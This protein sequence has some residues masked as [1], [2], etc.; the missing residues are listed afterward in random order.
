MSGERIRHLLKC[1]GCGK[2]GQVVFEDGEVEH[3][4]GAFEQLPKNKLKC[5]ECGSMVP[6]GDEGKGKKKR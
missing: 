3:L 5:E 1:P 6:Y 4:T 2:K